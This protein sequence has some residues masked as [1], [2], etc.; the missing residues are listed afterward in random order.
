MEVLPLQYKG[1]SNLTN[2]LFHP[3]VVFLQLKC[4]LFVISLHSLI[5][6][7]HTMNNIDQHHSQL[8]TIKLNIHPKI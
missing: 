6:G 3:F 4:N 1:P 7:A 8:G 5:P 2:T